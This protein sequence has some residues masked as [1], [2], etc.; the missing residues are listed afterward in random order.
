LHGRQLIHLQP[1]SMKR[2]SAKASADTDAEA[3][4]VVIR[5]DLHLPAGANSHAETAQ[6]ASSGRAPDSAQ[7]PAND[8]SQPSDQPAAV[9]D[10]TAAQIASSQ[11]HKKRRK[12]SRASAADAPAQQQAAAQ[13]PLIG[14]A[15]EATAGDAA[16]YAAAGAA[17]D[18]DAARDP[19]S[20]ESLQVMLVAV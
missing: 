10:G 3:H 19:L 2:R 7:Q 16:L 14:A 4:G 9:H 18:V 20:P 13:Q 1:T 5:K 6:T 15:T 17:A 11:K 8:A 12:S